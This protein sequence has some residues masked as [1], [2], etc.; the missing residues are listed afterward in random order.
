MWQREQKPSISEPGRAR[1]WWAVPMSKVEA[2]SPS[3]AKG[4]WRARDV[5]SGGAGTEQSPS[6][7]VWRA[8]SRKAERQMGSRQAFDIMEP[9][10]SSKMRLWQ[11]WHWPGWSMFCQYSSKGGGKNCA[12]EVT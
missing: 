3:L 10:H 2:H 4:L 1:V 11:D 6:V 9:F 5:P 12:S 8:E 7:E